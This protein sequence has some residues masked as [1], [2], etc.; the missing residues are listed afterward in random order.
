MI[1]KHNLEV[2]LG[3]HSYTL[4]MNQFGDL[5]NEEFRKQMNGYKMSSKD[6]SNSKIFSTPKDFVLPDDVGKLASFSFVLIYTFTFQINRLAY[7]R[8]CN[9]CERSR[10]M[11]FMLGFFNNRCT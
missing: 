8:L 4:A 1:N 9:I 11:W 2:D 3:L 10:S 7:K 6:E 5:N